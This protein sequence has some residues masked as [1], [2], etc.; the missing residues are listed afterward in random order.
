[1]TLGAYGAVRPG[2][3]KARDHLAEPLGD[4]LF[5]AGEATHKRVPALVNGAYLSGKKAAKKMLK[6]LA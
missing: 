5:F 2:A 6:V 4:R 1:L 3:P